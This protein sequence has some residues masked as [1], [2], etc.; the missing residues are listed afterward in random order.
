MTAGRR[1]TSKESEPVRPS[2]KSEKTSLNV[3]EGEQI[4]DSEDVLMQEL[5]ADK[6][7]EERGR[8][9]AEVEAMFGKSDDEFVPVPGGEQAPSTPRRKMPKK[10]EEEKPRPLL[11]EMQDAME[12]EEGRW[13]RTLKAPP[14][15]SQKEIDEHNATHCPFRIW[16]RYCVLGRAHKCAH[17]KLKEDEELK[18]PRVS[19]DYFYASGRDEKAKENPMLVVINEESGEKYARAVGNKGLENKEIAEWLIKDLSEEMKT[20]G[21]AGGVGGK[22]ILKCDG[23][24]AMT[25]M[26]DALGRFNG[27]TVIPEQS[28]KGESQ[29]NGRAEDAG[30]LVREFLRV[31]K[32]QVEGEAK[33]KIEGNEAITQWMIRWAAML[34]SRF[35]VGQDGRTGFERRRGRM[36]R[37]LVI[38]FAEY[39]WYRQIRKGKTQEDKLESEMKEGVWL[40]H[41]RNSNEVLIGTEHGVV[42]AYDVRRMPEGQRWNG[43]AINRMKG[44]PQQPDPKRPG[45][46]I[47]I[48]VVFDEAEEKRAVEPAAPKRENE[49]RRMRITAEMLEKYGY[50]E[51]CEGCRFKRAKLADNRAHSERCRK[52]IM[53][54]M[55]EDEEGRRKKKMD[56]DR[57]NNK[58]AVAIEEASRK[59]HFCGDPEQAEEDSDDESRC[60]RDSDDE[61]IEDAQQEE[62]K[63][64][65]EAISRFEKIKDEEKLQV[66]VAELFSP[67]R[68]T[69]TAKE[70]GLKAGMAMDLTNGWDFSLPRHRAAAE[71]YIK[72]FKPWIIIGSPECRMFSQMQNINRKYWNE[73]KDKMM[74]EA[75]EH[76]K[77]VMSMYKIQIKEGRFFL[78]EHPSEAS[79][80]F[81][82][83]VQEVMNTEGVIMTLADQC[84]Y[85][86]K[87]W[88]TV[89]GKLD[90]AAKKRTRFMTNCKG[91]AEELQKKCDAGHEHQALVDGRAKDAA[92]YPR[93]LCEAICRG[94]AKEKGQLVHQV[95]CLMTVSAKDSVGKIEGGDRG[96]LETDN[97]EDASG[98]TAWDDVSGEELSPKEVMKARLKEL[99]YIRQ[100]GVWKKITR[101]HAKQIG[102]KVVATRWID[103]NK[104]DLMEMNHRSRLVAK[105]FNDGKDASLFAATPPL[106]AL[107]LLVSEAATRDNKWK[108]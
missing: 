92:I 81:M 106:E 74:Q 35:L 65:H 23:E 24:K 7:P 39:V 51:G 20:W 76:V 52:R 47:P 42:R 108:K 60:P 56:E 41:A 79:S 38:P 46:G 13:A 73:E 58:M 31:L 103:V 91:V 82:K 61:M 71:K 6:S 94:I 9:E 48:R 102:I 77:F 68:V 10:K 78:H 99:E 4:E 49:I 53:D 1:L 105:E 69:I 85:G 54:K 33:I 80:W 45:A 107:R 89:R 59:R 2:K 11:E 19:M 86:L 67:P 43:E 95:K 84:M 28:A 64:I 100:K 66:D 14:I 29:S 26:R 62:Q 32:E 44:T 70:F 75:K 17:R 88:S 96:H 63:S 93:P 27:G 98:M 50:T 104:G 83:E 21:H 37:I 55:E 40:G 16:C 3:V 18:V 90:T 22:V 72:V 101:K 12:G 5:F 15:V 36:C 97:F 25:A 87:T 57:I 30:K 34:C 8:Q